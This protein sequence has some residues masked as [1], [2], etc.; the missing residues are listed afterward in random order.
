MQE[1]PQ[2]AAFIYFYITNVADEILD[3]G[4]FPTSDARAEQNIEAWKAATGQ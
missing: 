1:K 3:V 2:V 4:Y